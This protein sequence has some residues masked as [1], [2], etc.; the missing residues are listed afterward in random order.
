MAKL[1]GKDDMEK[2][3]KLSGKP[4]KDQAMWFLNYNWSKMFEKDDKKRLQIFKQTHDMINLDK[5]GVA[6][7]E[8]DEFE[9][10]RFLEIN[11]ETLTVPAM[12][13]MLREIDIDFNRKVSLTEYL[14]V[15]FKTDWHLLVNAVMSENTAEIEKAKAMC[16]DAQNKLTAALRGQETAE[17][18]ERE[19]IAAENE[20]RRALK[21][22]EDEENAYR[23]LM[24][25]L[26]AAKNDEKRGTVARNKASN[27]LDQLK[28]KD[29]L[30]LQRA[31]INQGAA[32][33]KSERATAAAAEA[34][35]AATAQAEAASKA[36]A[37]AQAY[38][39]EVS[40]HVG[41]LGGTMWWMG[42]ELEENKKYLPQSK[43][44]K[45]KGK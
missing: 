42:W 35:A 41:N 32:V 43:G 10:H 25:D 1:E 12:R 15:K 5:R 36:F 26:L 38:L 20:L 33:R 21:Q 3:K 19:Q 27:E 17:K 16:E 30:P 31:K 8:L 14:V 37:D 13:K 34:R 6:G 45:P 23:K 29:P 4:F 11:E 24:S 39:D 44:G 7:N 18:A 9:A 2:L 28:A 22:L 40:K